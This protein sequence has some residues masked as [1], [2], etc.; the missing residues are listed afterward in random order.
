MSHARTYFCGPQKFVNSQLRVKC[1]VIVCRSSDREVDHGLIVLWL[2]S[3][4]S[5]VD[6][7]PDR[8]SA[9]DVSIAGPGRRG[10]R[11]G[12]LLPIAGKEA[13]PNLVAAARDLHRRATQRLPGG[14]IVDQE[15]IGPDKHVAVFC[16]VFCLLS[17]V[18]CLALQSH[19][20]SDRS[21]SIVWRRLITC[22]W[23]STIM[24]S[25]GISRRL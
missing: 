2:G 24:T 25:A 16:P 3:D 12:R 6:V 22:G 9:S 10:R 19:R 8:T 5:V 4:G 13:V 7:A 1:P 20:S 21:S 18:L 15:I 23:P 11:L 17:S 14:H